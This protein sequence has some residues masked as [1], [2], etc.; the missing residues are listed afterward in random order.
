VHS[1]RGLPLSVKGCV[2]GARAIA[3]LTER[4]HTEAPLTDFLLCSQCCSECAVLPRCR[5]DL[6]VVALSSRDF[7]MQAGSSSI[8]RLRS[9]KMAVCLRSTTR[10]TCSWRSSLTLT[11]TRHQCFLTQGDRP[12]FSCS[13]TYFPLPHRL[14]SFPEL[15]AVSFSCSRIQPRNRSLLCPDLRL[16]IVP[17]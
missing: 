16:S 7:S 13:H 3:A 2:L 4:Q 11:L 10:H 14:C 5:W 15:C 17:L 8:P 9:V 12:S 1:G 6:S